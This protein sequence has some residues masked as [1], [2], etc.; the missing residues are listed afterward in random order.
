MVFCPMIPKVPKLGFLQLW[1]PI[2]SRADL[3]L[4]GDLK[5]SCSPHRE[6]FNDMLH[7][8]YTQINRVDS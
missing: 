3:G 2:T 7:A 6:L 8:T 1:G 4:R 5:Q